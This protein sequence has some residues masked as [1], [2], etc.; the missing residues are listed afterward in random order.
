MAEL[1]YITDQDVFLRFG[2]EKY[3]NEAL[4]ADGDGVYD[5]DRLL[6]AKRDA[7]EKIAAACQVQIDVQAAFKA[8]NIPQYMVTM[9]AQEAVWLIWQYATTGQACPK[10]VQTQHDEN[11][12]ELERIRTRER[13]IGAPEKYPSSSQ[14]LE[15]SN[16]DPRRTRMTVRNFSA[17]NGFR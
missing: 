10:F 2:G 5:Q 12:R 6:T 4:D 9:A 14:L 11:D 17:P 1:I 16:Y 8:G 15:K 3:L 13:S 7:C